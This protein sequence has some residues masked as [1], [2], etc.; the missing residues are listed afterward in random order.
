MGIME[1]VE[2]MTVVGSNS[3]PSNDYSYFNNFSDD[4]HDETDLTDHYDNL[5]NILHDNY[6]EKESAS[7]DERIYY[8]KTKPSQDGVNLNKDTR[9]SNQ[10]LLEDKIETLKGT[11]RSIES[12]HEWKFLTD[13]QKYPCTYQWKFHSKTAE[14]KIVSF[15]KQ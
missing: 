9:R 13:P 1:H 5:K 2:S 3:R 4:I 15:G 8:H 10:E 6:D 7:S 11:V 12:S 14:E